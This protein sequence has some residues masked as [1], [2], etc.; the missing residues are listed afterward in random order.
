MSRMKIC[1]VTGTRAEFGLL[2]PL[3]QLIND[4]SEFILQLIVTGSH[5]SKEF[6]DT[7]R[8]IEKGGYLI[9]SKVDILLSSDSDSAISKSMG[10]AM[11]SFADV[12]SRLNP[13]LL[14]VL[15]DR[16]EI[17]SVVSS[18]LIFKIPIAH[19]H[20]GELTEGA[21][22]NSIRHAITKMSH[23]HFC[24]TDIYRNRIIQMGEIP[25][26]VFNVGAIG[27]DSIV[28]KELLSCEEL[29]K[30]ISF[31]LSSP[32][33]LF[34]FHPETLSTS[35]AKEQIENILTALDSLKD[36]KI[37]FTYANADKDGRVINELLEQYVLRNSNQSIVFKSMGQ[38]RYLS[39]MKYCHCV[40]GNSSSGVLE[41]PSFRC[42]T[43]NIGNRQK[44]RIMAQTVEQSDF[45]IKNIIS[46]LKNIDENINNRK[47][48]NVVS[49]YGCGT[50]AKQIF[51]TISSIKFPV[52]MVKPFYDMETK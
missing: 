41:A 37:I 33:Y 42:P 38:L 16:F 43:L 21:Y 7:Y 40:V 48:N 49:P 45:E 25:S 23:F 52:N 47:Y 32:Y 36:K 5:L 35:S 19:I 34:T 11:I 9:D 10:L 8:Q 12:F 27:I 39:A 18:A 6:G 51:K 22:D 2:E 46:V 15:G 26:S 30:Q 20:G 28:N 44:G 29:S 14:I 1:V 24:S 4:S 3:I 50:S 13:N 31:D 17:L